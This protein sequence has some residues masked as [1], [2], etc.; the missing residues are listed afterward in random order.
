MKTKRKAVRRV[1]FVGNL[2]HVD[3][4]LDV[5]SV[6]STSGSPKR[7]HALREDTFVPPTSADC[8][9][10]KRRK[11]NTHTSSSSMS[12]Q[13]HRSVSTVEGECTCSSHIAHL[14]MPNTGQ[15]VDADLISDTCDVAMQQASTEN[16]GTVSN[17]T[18]DNSSL[19]GSNENPPRT[20]KRERCTSPTSLGGQL[21]NINP[22]NT[23]ENCTRQSKRPGFIQVD[24]ASFVRSNEN[25]ARSQKRQRRTSLNSIGGQHQNIN[26]T[27]GTSLRFIQV[28]PNALCTS[29]N[30]PDANRNRQRRA[31]QVA[32]K[33]ASTAKLFFGMTSESR[34]ANE[35]FQSTIDVA[36]MEKLYYL[37]LKITHTR[38]K[39]QDADVP[40][41]KLKLF[42]V[43]GS[44]QYDL[45]TGDSVGAVVFE[46]GPDVA[47]DYDVI[48]QKHGGQPQ[49]IDKLNPHYMSL[50]FPL[51]FIYG[52]DGYHLGL[53][54]LDKAGEP[55]EKDKQM[56]MKILMAGTS[57]PSSP[58]KDYG[59]QVVTESQ[60][61]VSKHGSPPNT[62]GK[63]IIG[64]PKSTSLLT[65]K[66][67]DFDT[68]LYVKVYRKWTTINKASVPVMH[69]CIL[70]DQ[71]EASTPKS[72]KTKKND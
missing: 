33:Y 22:T 50:H 38:D 7:N 59:K 49:R 42:G 41:F 71:Q 28:T 72:K 19:I 62:Q 37:Q 3:L 1:P 66:R 47:T 11:M 30:L 16:T 70:L 48:I 25:S 60:V 5:A 10:Q 56:S 69:S 31:R 26:P 52:E 43:V 34:E 4:S 36:T 12:G 51:F 53:K 45:P 27:H 63:E 6:C 15:C 29:N 64:L 55:A 54:L 13:D 68:S 23:P 8:R 14:H 18:V 32:M 20:R 35:R 40:D 57:D 39:L 67:T 2:D 44:R 24:N 65:L 9:K 61:T 21:Q 58:P 46:G 17:A